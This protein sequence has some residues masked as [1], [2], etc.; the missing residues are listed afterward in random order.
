MPVVFASDF[1]ALYDSGAALWRGQYIGIYPLPI[2]GLFALLALLPRPIALVVITIAGLML[3]VAS[4]RRY[5][6]AWMF[7]YPILTCL[8]QGQFDLMWLWLLRHG[9]P[10]ALALLT[11]K[12]QLFPLALPAL[13]ADHAKWRPFALACAALYGPVTLVRPTWPL[14]WLAQLNDGRLGWY[15]S[16][17]VL[18]Y[19]LAGFA[20]LLAVAALVRLDWRAVFWTCNPTLRWYDFSLLAGGSLWLIPLSWVA[21]GMTQALGGHPAPVAILGIADALLRARKRVGE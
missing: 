9:S 1:N 17:I 3:F 14:E 20:I 4:F 6:L 15:S 11:L 8:W 21:W 7:F 2:N 19:P 13:L 16:S 5:A 18:E 10:V 12:P